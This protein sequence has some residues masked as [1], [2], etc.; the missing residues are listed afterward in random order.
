MTV[1]Q[2]LSCLNCCCYFQFTHL[3]TDSLNVKTTFN[4]I[5]LLLFLLVTKLGRVRE[6]VELVDLSNRGK[7]TRHL[8][9]YNVCTCYNVIGL[10]SLHSHHKIEHEIGPASA[11]LDELISYYQWAQQYSHINSP[12]SHKKHCQEMWC[13]LCVGD[14]TKYYQLHKPI[15]FLQM[16]YSSTIRVMF[17]KKDGQSVC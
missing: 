9:C 8:L 17:D 12:S 14:I 7:R 1:L 2:A 5:Q 10:L 11:T 4:I 16:T 3:D 6:E 13:W 15:D